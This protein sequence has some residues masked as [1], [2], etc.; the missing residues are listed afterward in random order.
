MRRRKDMSKNSRM[1]IDPLPG[2][3]C[4]HPDLLKWSGKGGPLPRRMTEHIRL[5]PG[6]DEQVRRVS[7]VHA[8]LTLLRNQPAPHGLYGRA[9]GR[10]M[11]MLMRVARASAAA[12]Q[13]LKMKPDLS[14]WQRAR[15]HIARISLGAVAA[16]LVLVTRAGVNTGVQETRDLGERLAAAHWD[17]HIDPN[18]EWLDPPRMA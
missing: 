14:P 9:N 5:C 10:A 4:E 12:S 13:L 15:I 6:C 7:E 2:S 16:L 8:G 17:R 1:R 11:R 3:G 18:H